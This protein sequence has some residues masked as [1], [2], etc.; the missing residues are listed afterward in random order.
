MRIAELENH[1]ARLK[2]EYGNCSVVI[3][4]ESQ[5]P[6]RII[7]EFSVGDALVEDETGDGYE[8]VSIKIPALKTKSGESDSSDL[9]Q[10]FE[11]FLGKVTKIIG[12]ALA[13]FEDQCK[14][15]NSQIKE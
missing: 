6:D 12:D 9:T 15:I 14:Q 13:K 1:L 10:E 8:V 3:E 2:E 7:A 4:D 5:S 11:A